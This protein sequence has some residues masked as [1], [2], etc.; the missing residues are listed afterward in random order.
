MTYHVR[1][2]GVWKEI[3]DPQVRDAGVWKPVQEGWVRDAGTW[4][5]FYAR[6]QPAHLTSFDVNHF[7]LPGVT[8][9]AGVVVASSGAHQRLQ[10]AT[11]TTVATW[12]NSGAAG[13][14]EVRA[15]I[16][17]GSWGS[18]L[19]CGTTRSWAVSSVTPGVAATQTVDLEIRLAASPFTVYSSS[20]HFL[21][22]TEGV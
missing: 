6:I 15:R 2:A 19:N 16:N 1:D 21:S 8:A 9:Q 22:A 20:T 10:G 4:K 12:L 17:G 13:D 11:F 14:Y 7:S 18:W 3:T 5:Q